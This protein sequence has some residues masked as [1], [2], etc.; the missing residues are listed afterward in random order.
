MRYLIPFGVALL[1]AG[2]DDGDFRSHLPTS[3]PTPLR[4][5]VTGIWRGQL[6]FV[7]E[8]RTQALTIRVQLDQRGQEFQGAWVSFRD[9]TVTGTVS[10]T[11]A[12]LNVPTPL[13]AEWTMDAPTSDGGRC[14]GA[15]QTT[16]LAFP[17]SFRGET[18]RF[19]RCNPLTNLQWR[20]EFE[21]G[22]SDGAT[23]VPIQPPIFADNSNTGCVPR[24]NGSIVIVCPR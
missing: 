7:N 12:S 5:D 6:T 3:D 22:P 13:T 2:C 24:T 18:W 14:K 16:G 8:G 19:D 17:L 20:L 11:L 15:A 1:L 10:G 4:A 23:V 9:E 21:R